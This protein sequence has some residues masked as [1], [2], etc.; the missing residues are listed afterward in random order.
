MTGYT[1]TVGDGTSLASNSTGMQC[2]RRR[3]D[4]A[5]EAE[6]AG[7]SAFSAT[8]TLA[9]VEVPAGTFVYRVMVRVLK[10][11]GGTLTADIGDG[12]DPDGFVDGVDLNAL[13]YN[14]GVAALTE[15]TPNTFTGYTGGKLYTADD[16]LDLLINNNTAET[17]VFDVFVFFAN[18]NM[19]PP[20]LS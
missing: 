5:K 3:I 15:G 19:G 13:G 18:V 10:V 14:A 4:L 20:L 9:F 6:A 2:F 1:N 7:I 16:T 17:A 11:E 8:D 12:T